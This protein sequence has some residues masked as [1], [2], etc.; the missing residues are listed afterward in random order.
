MQTALAV[1]E[2]VMKIDRGAALRRHLFHRRR[3]SCS[4]RRDLRLAAPLILWL[5]RLPRHACATSSRACGR[6]SQAQADARSMMTGRVVDSYTNISTVKMFAHADRE[7][8][9]ARDGMDA[10]L[11]T[12]HQQMRLV[13]L[14]TVALNALN[15]LLLFSVAGAVALAVVD[16]CRHRRRHRRCR[17]PGAAPAGHVALDHVGGRG[18]VRERSAPCRTASRRS[19]AS[20]ASSTRPTPSRSSCRRGEI[21]F[22]HIRFNY[23]KKRA[24]AR[25]RHRRS[26][27]CT[28]SAR[29]EGRP[30]R[31]L[32][33]RQVD[34]RQP[35]AALLR[36]R[37]RPHADRRPGHRA[38]R[39]RTA[40]ARRSAW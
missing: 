19:R 16:R 25:Q 31:P 23:G 13:T 28:V 11:G 8:V 33:R 4:R 30:R 36:P 17:R 2:V 27:A 14:L 6:I 1:R 26:V 24:E 20:A 32:G 18:A 3:L 38:G 9:Y 21:R 40:C 7:D 34:A 39:R 22:E 15:A 12:V 5:G 29:R 35:A 10:F 37:G